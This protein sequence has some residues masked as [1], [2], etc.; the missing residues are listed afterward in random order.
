MQNK[1]IAGVFGSHYSQFPG[2]RLQV[3]VTVK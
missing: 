2:Q 1:Q 3:N